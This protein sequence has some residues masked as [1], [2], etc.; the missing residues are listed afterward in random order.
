MT[1]AYEYK[2]AKFTVIFCTLATLFSVVLSACSK[3]NDAASDASAAIPAVAMVKI[4]A[5]E[6][7]RG[8]DKQDKEG[9]QQRFGFPYPLYK[10]E[11]PMKKINLPAYYI[12]KFEVNNAQYKQYIFSSKQMIPYDWMSNGYA[13]TDEQLDKMTVEKLRKLAAEYARLDIDTTK[14]EKPALI[15]AMRAYHASLDK[16]PVGN[17]SW[18]EAQEYCKWRG[19]RL[20]SEAEWEKAARGANGNV[21]PWGNEWN[22]KY[23]NTGDDGEWEDGIAPVGSYPKNVSPFG[24]MDMAGNVW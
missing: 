12:D 9:L 24:V 14:M 10:D 16:F 18:F 8:S 7:I 6:F 23:A 21:Y 13:L 17:V 1:A 11:T 19:A 15:K 4:A 3:S 22:P 20:P 5:G 2:Y